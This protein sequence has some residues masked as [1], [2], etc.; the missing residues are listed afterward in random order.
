MWLFLLDTNI[1]S[2]L[3]K[4]TSPA[5]VHRARSVQR[6]E[7]VIS[8]ITEAEMRFGFE[9]LPPEAK[10]RVTI[11]EFLES[12]ESA[13]W[14][15]FCAQRYGPLAAAQQKSGKPLSIADTMIAAHALALGLTLVTNDKAFSHIKG[16]RVEDWTKGPHP[17]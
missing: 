5:L 2:F 16:L 11:P 6:T 13:P 3:A 17:S 10:L 9:R 7:L 8:T 4:G 14:D 15:S 12:M 1:A